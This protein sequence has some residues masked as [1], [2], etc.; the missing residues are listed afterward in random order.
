MGNQLLMGVVVHNPQYL[1]IR[2]PF[3]HRIGLQ[4]QRHRFVNAL[5][6]QPTDLNPLQKQQSIK[7]EAGSIHPIYRHT[8]TCRNGNIGHIILAENRSSGLILTPDMSSIILKR[9]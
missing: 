1:S 8:V 5:P 4:S 7:G 9:G 6:G 3:H 2:S